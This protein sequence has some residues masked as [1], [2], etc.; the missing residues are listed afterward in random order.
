MREFMLV[1]HFIGLAM[2]L[3]TGF[4]N[5]FLGIAMSKMSP[6]E[7][8]KFRLQALVLTR[9]G[10]IGLGL[11]IL[12]G[13]YLMMPYYMTLGNNTLLIIKLVMVVILITIVTLISINAG[14]AKKGDADLHFKKIGMLGRFSLLTAIIIVILAVLIFH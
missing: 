5:M 13:L 3:G 12:S 4:A 9:M 8:G 11:L 6:E 2:G 10:H 1:L 14:K 7:A